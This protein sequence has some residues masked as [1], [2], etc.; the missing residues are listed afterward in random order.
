MSP[1]Y[2]KLTRRWSRILTASITRAERSPSGWPKVEN[3][4]IATRGS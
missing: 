1:S 4:S 3:A 2:S